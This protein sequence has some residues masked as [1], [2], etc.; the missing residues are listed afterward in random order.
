MGPKIR[1]STQDFVLFSCKSKGHVSVRAL[2]PRR[3]QEPLV[4]F[5]NSRDADTQVRM[6]DLG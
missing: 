6:R 1:F 3:E 2:A 4:S 5:A